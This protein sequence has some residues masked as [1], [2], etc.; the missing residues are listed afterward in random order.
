MGYATRTLDNAE[1]AG[2]VEEACGRR[3]PM[4]PMLTAVL[5]EVVHLSPIRA[6]ALPWCSTAGAWHLTIV[7]RA[8]YRLAPGVSSL[9]EEP[10][11]PCDRDRHV[12]D[13]PERSL[14]H[15]SDLVPFK[16]RPEVL[17]V[18][19]AFAPGGQPVRALVVRMAVGRI[20]KSIKVF[21]ERYWSKDGKVVQAGSFSSMPL[22]YERAAGGPDTWNPV[23][24]PLD[25][26]FDPAKARRVALPNLQP[27]GMQLVRF[28]DFVPPICFG[29]LSPTWE[30]RAQQ[31]GRHRGALLAP[32]WRERPLP[33]D[34]KP[35]YFNAAVEDQRLDHL[36]SDQRI[37]LQNLHADHAK[38]VTKLPGVHPKVFVEAEGGRAQ[39]EEV[40]VRCDTLSIDG[41]R[42][43]CALVWRGQVPVDGPDPRGR[44]VVT[45]AKPGEKIRWGEIV[46]ANRQQ[47][48]HPAAG[49]GDDAEDVQEESGSPVIPEEP[50]TLTLP[51]GTRVRPPTPFRDVLAEQT[52]EDPTSRGA[53][54]AP[55]LPFATTPSRASAAFVAPGPALPALA[56]PITERVPPMVAGAPP[57]PEWATPPPE[58]A[59][60]PRVVP[61]PSAVSPPVVS[62]LA[63]SPPAAS[64][65]AARGSAQAR[66]SPRI[67]SWRSPG[68]EAPVECKDDS[69]SMG[70]P[71]L[72]GVLAASNAA[73]EP[74]QRGTG[75]VSVQPAQEA[76]HR[77]P[78]SDGIELV[79]LDAKVVPRMRKH[80][81]WKS[82]LAELKDL[83]SRSR[84]VDGD[85]DARDRRQE[86]KDRRDVSLILRRGAARDAAGIAAAL[87]EALAEDVFVPPLVLVDGELELPFDEMATLAATLAAVAPFVPGDRK[88]K[89]T[90]DMIA[91]VLKTP[92]IER[93]RGVA[94]GL[95][96]RLKGAFGTAGRGVPPTYL[97]AQTEPMLLEGRCY[98]TR[99]VMGARHLRAM[100]WPGGARQEPTPVYLPESLKDDLPMFRRFRVKLVAEVRGRV[101][102]QEAAEW[103]L[104]AAALG[105]VTKGRR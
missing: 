37:V 21:G 3:A 4:M 102:Q 19:R 13:D 9:H 24:L 20:D 100:S 72:R 69:P 36:A 75:G 41:E 29:P 10:E 1:R 23:G 65:P 51:I 52:E 48:R 39:P 32:G 50:K 47:S 6:A 86:D 2:V 104:K 7:C 79:W 55:V 22:V 53:P 14:S 73:L 12:E 83:R 78:P 8:T 18:G 30:I 101:D 43:L 89:E 88:L 15:A 31:L 61:S 70:E 99:A 96:V 105:R 27:P 85:D 95:L 44:L 92:G 58:I 54:K 46:A 16:A 91:E 26:R 40:E 76:P 62:P 103:A 97:E 93:A 56:P 59:P 60:P 77:T 35:E 68:S 64:P 80:P 66:P 38:L 5:M 90:V 94:E 49:R 81:A 57:S 98:Q 74:A 33:E 82:L 87:D 28:G 17:L 25:A 84:D 63:T 34:L 67:G 11:D 71:V 42:G 45:M